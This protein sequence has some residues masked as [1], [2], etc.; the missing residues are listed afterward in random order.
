M[1][2]VLDLLNDR[3]AEI[4]SLARLSPVVAFEMSGDRIRSRDFLNQLP[5]LKSLIV[6]ANRIRSINLSEYL[7]DLL[8]LDSKGNP[9]TNVQFCLRLPNLK[10]IDAGGGLP[11]LTDIESLH[12]LRGT[13]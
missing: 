4:S 11:S 13:P 5:F 7:L 12:I 1:S 3:I 2:P 9:L 6:V 10:C 8:F